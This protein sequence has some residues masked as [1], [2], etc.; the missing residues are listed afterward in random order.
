MQDTVLLEILNLREKIN[1]ANY[2][3]HTLD[4][5]TISD[6]EYDKAM[7]RLIS[8]EEEYPNY[9]DLSSPTNKIGGVILENFTKVIHNPPMMS[10]GDVFNEYELLDFFVKASK[11]ASNFTLVSELKIDG[12]AINLEYINGVLFRASTRGDGNIGEDVTENVKT[13]KSIPLKLN[14]PLD[15]KVRGEVFMPIK[16]FIKLNIQRKEN[17]EQLFANPRNAASG[18]IRQLD[19]KIVSSRN[20][21]SFI[22]TL[23]SP[24]TYNIH[25]QSSSLEF[26]RG[27]GFKVNNYYKHITSINELAP[28]ITYYDNLREEVPYDTDGIVIKINEFNLYDEIGYTA[29]APK[30]AVAYKFPPKTKKTKLLDIIFQVGR[31]GAITPVAVFESVVVSGSKISRASLHN[32]DYIKDKD[33]RIGDIVEVHKA[34]EIIPEI[35]KVVLEQRNINSVPFEMIKNCPIC[36]SLLTRDASKADYFCTNLECPGRNINSIIH[37]ASRKALDIDTL[38]EKAIEEFHN[39]GI[40]NRLSD[41]YT[42]KDKKDI[43]LELEG[44]GDKKIDNIISSIEKSKTISLDRFIYGLGIKN[45]GEKYSKILV[46]HYKTITEL[47]Q[48]DEEVLVNIND[49]GVERASSVYQYF[50]NDENIKEIKLLLGYGVNPVSANENVTKNDF[51]VNKKI[52]ITGSFT[53][54]TRDELTSLLE[55]YGAKVSS[56]VSSQTSYLIV[57]ENPGSKLDKA[58]LLGIKIIKED[59]LKGYLTNG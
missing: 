54:F 50:H 42:L 59:E 51:F 19:S 38:G 39:I 55:S 11:D 57:G 45:I 26:M 27:L 3:Y 13:I 41:I 8:L 46:R 44:F 58:L 17:N 15:I 33:I 22:Y 34:A 21:D 56:S 40:L 25:T 49:F 18:T 48:V 43:I 52:V 9:K 7:S 2:E 5:P 28:L 12:L 20:L 14:K 30:W 53:I 36:N 23:V 1:K 24:S 47:F 16:S 32:E 10:L 4:N 31:T 35:L 37:Y 29:K 6:Y